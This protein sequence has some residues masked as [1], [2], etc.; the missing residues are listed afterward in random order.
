MARL[1]KQIISGGD[2]VS[3]TAGLSA[4]SVKW[5]VL[6][7]LVFSHVPALPLRIVSMMIWVKCF[8]LT[9]RLFNSRGR[10]CAWIFRQ[11]RYCRPASRAGI[12]SLSG[13]QRT[14]DV[15]RAGCDHGYL[16]FSEETPLAG[17]QSTVAFRPNF[18]QMTAHY[19]WLPWTRHRQPCI[20]RASWVFN[21]YAL[22]LSSLLATPRLKRSRNC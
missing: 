19:F 7:G 14:L 4:G 6:V 12:Q 15:L 17:E 10:A 8:V 3:R 16:I 13:N 20:P 1:G 22:L 18:R 5:L 21:S 11:L 9:D 2:K